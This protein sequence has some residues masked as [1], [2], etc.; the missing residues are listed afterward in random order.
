MSE[1]I[2]SNPPSLPVFRPRPAGI[3]VAS[4]GE[5]KILTKLIRSHV[6]NGN[7]RNF[8][9]KGADKLGKGAGRGGRAGTGKVST[10]TR[11]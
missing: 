2:A 8:K 1:P 5:Q 10:P 9:V 3:P 6:Q 11:K 4:F 7:L